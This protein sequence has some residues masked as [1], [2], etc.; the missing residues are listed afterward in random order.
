MPHGAVIDA[1]PVDLSAD[2]RFVLLRLPGPGGALVLRDRQLDVSVRVPD[3]QPAPDAPGTPVARAGGASLSA[4]GSFVDVGITRPGVWRWSRVDGSTR[5][6]P[7]DSTFAASSPEGQVA[8]TGGDRHDEVYL[9]NLTTG[10]SGPVVPGSGSSQTYWSEL[11]AA[12]RTMATYVN[13]IDWLDD[14]LVLDLERSVVLDRGLAFV[15]GV[16]ADGQWY[17][18]DD[19]SWELQV[20][21]TDGIASHDAFQRRPRGTDALT[22]HQGAAALDGDGGVLAYAS[23]A[24]DLVPGVRPDESQVY[25]WQIAR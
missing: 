21:R 25:V 20:R 8:A 9:R 7:L 10:V 11:G 13:T 1:R 22:S 15:P 19:R 2:G 6:F 17:T 3:P 5:T 12:G 23:D 14:R 24:V 4:D 16:S 18:G